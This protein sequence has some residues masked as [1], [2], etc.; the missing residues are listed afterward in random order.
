MTASEKTKIT[1]YHGSDKIITKPEFEKGN[2]DNDYGPGF[3]TTEDIDK[4]RAW[5]VLYG[6]K[7]AI[8]NKYEIDVK[9]MNILY[10]DKYGPLAWIAEIIYNRYTGDRKSVV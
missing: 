7:E 3:Y 6:G 2:Y 8:N 4:A 1:I 9:D 10:L 5:S